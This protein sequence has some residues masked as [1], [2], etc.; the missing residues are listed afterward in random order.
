MHA[1]AVF[2]I[3]FSHNGCICFFGHIFPTMRFKRFP[4]ILAITGAL[5][6]ICAA[7]F[8]Y[9]QAASPVTRLIHTEP[10]EFAPVVVLEEFGQRCMNF[11]TIEDNGRHTCMDL[12]DPDK[13]VFG[14]T[15]MMTTA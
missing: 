7:L 5:L 11:N 8:F 12:N 9:S 10:S 4:I 3:V 6:A 13:M 2:G 1:T 15:R 14:Y